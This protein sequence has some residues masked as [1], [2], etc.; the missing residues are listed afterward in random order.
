MH[1]K[2][3]TL[4]R[5]TCIYLFVFSLLITGQLAN[6][7]IYSHSFGT[8]TISTHPYTIAP[9]ILD[10]HLQNSSWSNSVS[11]WTST[12]GATGEAIRI[13]T[14]ATAT[15]TLNFAVTTGFKADITA[16]DFWRLRSN[17]GPQNWTMAINGTIVGSGTTG[18]AGAAL[19]NTPVSTPVTG[20]TGTVTVT[21]TI[22]NSA[23]NGTFRLDDFKLFGTVTSNCTAATIS[24]FAPLSG[25]QNT[26]VTINGSGFQ[27]GGGTTAVR[28][29]GLAASGFTVISD[30]KIEAYL[31]AGNASGNVS[32]VTNGCEGFSPAAFTVIKTTTANNYSSDIYI[33][34][35]YD[36]QAG[37]GGVIEIYNGTATTVNLSGYTITRAG[38]V[39]GPVNYT[40][41]LSGTIPPGGVYLIGIGTGVIPCG[42]T[43]S[44]GQ[45]Y[46]TGFNANDEFMLYH[47]GTLID[48]IQT[49]NNVGYSLIRNPNA[50][51]PK[52]AFNGNDWNQNSSNTESCTDIG[53]HHVTPVTVPVVTSPTSKSACESKNVSFTAPLSNPAGY[54]FQWKVL[55]AAGSWV[56]VLNVAPYSNVTTNTLTINPVPANFNANQYY[57]QMTSGGNILVSNASQLTV[58]PALIADF[59]TPLNICSGDA[60]TIGNTS[61]NGVAGTWSSA[62][63]NTVGATY[64][65]TPNAGQCAV[66]QTLTITITP[67]KVANFPT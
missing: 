50:I 29:N 61:P 8:T 59:P 43:A 31:P 57:C 58:T 44:Q 6:A 65:F 52:T 64:T 10:S 47:S 32:V 42:W 1:L 3:N 27:A 15:I 53:V 21:I 35:L 41:N 9:D 19:G 46:S 5:K 48:N 11:A 40:I 60:I 66:G 45:H 56:N 30:A 39:G 38:D 54:S 51:A 26:L 17:L 23:G 49:P 7:Q 33:S 2:T 34:E 37:D 20:L 13:T 14:A 4:I 12:T 62:F 18:T 24:S 36:A 25:P 16:F 55:N 22:S 67:P 63:S 28:F